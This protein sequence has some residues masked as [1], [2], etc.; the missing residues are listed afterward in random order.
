[1]CCVCM[2]Q[3]AR[4]YAC[5]AGIILSL[6]RALSDALTLSKSEHSVY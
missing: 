1:M 4:D 2:H 3:N 6:D 5:T